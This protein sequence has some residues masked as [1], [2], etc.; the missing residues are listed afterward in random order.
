MFFLVSWHY[1]LVRRLPSVGSRFIVMVGIEHT[2]VLRHTPVFSQVLHC[3]P[4]PVRDYNGN[5][6]F[7]WMV[8]EM[9]VE[10]AFS[11]PCFIIGVC[12]Y[13]GL[14]WLVGYCHCFFRT[15]CSVYFIS[16]HR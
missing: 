4:V 2:I 14:E 15:L 1:F 11:S 12:L 6:G 5:R 8:A 9:T 16:R 3:K 7:G 10:A 13:S